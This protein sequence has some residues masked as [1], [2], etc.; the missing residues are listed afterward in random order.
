MAVLFIV[1]HA[2]LVCQIYNLNTTKHITE[3]PFGL[4]THRALSRYQVL[5]FQTPMLIIMEELSILVEPL[6]T[7]F[8]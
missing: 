1:T 4:I 8:N 3:E 7:I 5:R 2:D 6:Q